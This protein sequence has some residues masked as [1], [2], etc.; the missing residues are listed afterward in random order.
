M[1]SRRI[2]LIVP[3]MLILSLA[4]ASLA[5]GASHDHGK[6]DPKG[7]FSASLIGHNETPAIHTAGQGTLSLTIDKTNH[8]M[9]YELTYSNL[10]SPASAA[11]VHFGQK[12][13]AGGVSFYLCGGTKPACPAGNTSTS[14]SVS[15][16]I[17]AVDVLAIP[18]QGMPAGD[19]VAIEQEM[20]DGFTYANVHTANFAGGEIRGQLKHGHGHGPKH[21]K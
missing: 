8:A 14:V 13:V 5:W 9:T 3:A 18:T 12:N 10:S 11:H 7:D 17:N 2:R 6:K 4:A 20:A 19:L 16:Q 15:G 1:S 21:N